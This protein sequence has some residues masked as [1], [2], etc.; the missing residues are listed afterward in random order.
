MVELTRQRDPL[1]VG[2]FHLFASYPRVSDVHPELA[3]VAEK[4]AYNP[5]YAPN[6][7]TR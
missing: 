7:S 1:V 6:V 4:N 5:K 3:G 2:P